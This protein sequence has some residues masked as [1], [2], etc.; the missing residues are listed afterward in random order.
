V[1]FPVLTP[2]EVGEN[3]MVTVQLLPGLNGVTVEQL[4][5]PE[6]WPGY[7]NGLVNTS[8]TTPVFVR[9]K[10]SVVLEIP[11]TAK[12]KFRE[13]ADRLNTGNGTGVGV[14]VGA[15]VGVGVG[16]GVGGGAG[17][18]PV[19]ESCTRWGEFAALV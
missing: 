3:L 10:V 5:E 11:A 17:R 13:V 9:V 19:P 14:G 4:P 18:A 6:Y 1:K 15:G 8:G 2:P 12:P 16:V 7:V